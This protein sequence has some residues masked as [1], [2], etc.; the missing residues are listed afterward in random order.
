MINVLTLACISFLHSER[1]SK[2]SEDFLTG[3]TFGRALMVDERAILKDRFEIIPDFL[4]VV[5]AH[6][7]MF[8]SG[9]R[10]FLGRDDERLH[11]ERDKAPKEGESVLSPALVTAAVQIARF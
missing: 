7:E 3:M 10:A 6:Q 1:I 9:L 5:G 8:T 11:F 2:D 4:R